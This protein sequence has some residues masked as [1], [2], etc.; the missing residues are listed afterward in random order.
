[1][2]DVVVGR[3]RVWNQSGYRVSIQDLERVRST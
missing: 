3:M 2:V 1:M